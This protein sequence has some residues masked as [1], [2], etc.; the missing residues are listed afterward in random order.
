MSLSGPRRATS[1]CERTTHS[2]EMK[3][4]PIAT[5]FE[6]TFGCGHVGTIDLSALPPDRRGGR[7]RLPAGQGVVRRLLRGH[8]REAPRARPPELGDGQA[9]GGGC[10]GLGVGGPRRVRPAGRQRQAGRVRQPR[11]LRPD[12][13]ALRVGRPGRATTRPVTHASRRPPK[14]STRPAGGSTSAAWSASPPI[15]TCSSC[16]TP[17]PTPTTARSA[18]TRHEDP[19]R[20]HPPRLRRPGRRPGRLRRVTHRVLRHVASGVWAVAVRGRHRRP[21]HRGARSAPTCA[22]E[23]GCAGTRCPTSPA[24]T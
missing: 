18:R 24:P 13:P 5:E 10:R 20:A 1:P 3:R 11:P 4:M 12:A 23:H 19:A 15:A 21:D 22:P 9:Q 16:W 14:R 2:R 17:P 7:D 8:P 6:L